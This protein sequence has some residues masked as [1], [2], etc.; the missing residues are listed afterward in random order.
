MLGTPVRHPVAAAAPRLADYDYELPAELIAQVPAAERDAA[1]LLVL[2]RRGGTL[3]HAAVRD[4]PRF[5]TAGDLLVFNDA[6]VRPA[7]LACRTASGAAVELLVLAARAPRLWSCLGRPAKRLRAGAA[8]VL[9]AGGSA[10]VREA[11]G[12]GRYAVEFG[13]GVDVAALLARHGVLPLPPYIKR[14]DGPLALDRERYQTIFADRAAAVAAPTAG[15]H[16]TPALLAALDAA[17]V[18]RATLTLAVGP[19]TFLPV[20]VDDVRRYH[21]E[22]ER[23]DLPP[24]TVAAIER[25]RAAGGRVVAVGTTTARA[26]ESAALAA[27]AARP[28][29]AVG[30]GVTGATRRRATGLGSGRFWADVFIVPGFSF[31]VVDALLTNF[32]LPR[33][34]LLMLVSAFAGRERIREAY[35]VAVQER[36][37]FYS[38]GDAM[39]IC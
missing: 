31:R 33:S 25:T 24:A 8:L 38:Y 29:G 2:E 34:T 39:L 37:R 36:Y 20:R 18:K 22:P 3:R 15:L 6:R 26:L 23:V 7:R 19:G 5:L 32:H 13:A 12:A 10:L 21:M 27:S 17:G 28:V 4:L 11:V 14:P 30:R 9:P 16:F 1:R 35:A